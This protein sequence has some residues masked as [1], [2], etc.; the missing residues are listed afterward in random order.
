MN[1]LVIAAILFGVGA[2][3]ESASAQGSAPEQHGANGP[4][5]LMVANPIESFIHNRVPA[6]A[7]L[8]E[9]AA[10]PGAPNSY[11]AIYVVHPVLEPAAPIDTFR[12]AAGNLSL[13]RYGSCPAAN[14]QVARGVYHLIL[15]R[16]G[17]VVNDVAI[18]GDPEGEL[19]ATDPDALALSFRN[20]PWNLFGAGLGPKPRDDD[21]SAWYDLKPTPLL[22]LR[23]LTGSG[24][25]NAFL[26]RVPAEPCGF[27][28][29][30]VAG[31]DATTDRAVVYP[32][33]D[34]GS[35]GSPSQWATNF[36]PDSSGRVVQQLGGCDHGG[37]GPDIRRIY[38]F[39]RARRAYI[40]VREEQ[41][42]CRPSR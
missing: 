15:F 41:S 16:D 21:P 24:V 5:D 17:A 32:I 34:A 9:V 19:Y 20:T 4:V 36:I 18:P 1:R 37:A 7:A 14:G 6:G 25:A 33:F 22:A 12:N 31:Y 10:V 8:R 35:Q 23:D 13:T 26:M 2:G 40:F 11:L 30:L 39:D 28:R 42:A 27:T 38:Q 3:A 29:F